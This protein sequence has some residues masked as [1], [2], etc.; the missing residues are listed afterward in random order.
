MKNIYFIRHGKSSHNL[1][2]D[3]NGRNAY[4]DVIHTDS[5]LLTEGFSQSVDI[6]SENKSFFDDILKN[7]YKIFVSPLK[8]C[9]MTALVMFNNYNLKNKLICYENIREYPCGLHTPNK[10]MS[11][12]TL[13]YFYGKYIDFSYIE[14]NED[15]YWNT[16]REETIVELEKRINEF[17]KFLYS[18]E[19]TNIIVI[20]HS[21]F[22]GK[23]LFND[24]DYNIEHKKIYSYKLN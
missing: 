22:I 21:S 1:D 15:I 11:K 13:E 14:E 3:I 7:D 9:I 16:M 23:F 19:E 5:A 18:L 17:K 20:S 4:I 8:R 24:I 10:R 12:N 2:Y 6:I